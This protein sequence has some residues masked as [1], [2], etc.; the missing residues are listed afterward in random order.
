[1]IGNIRRGVVLV[2]TKKLS[3]AIVEK[4]MTQ[5][6]VAAAIGATPKAFRNKMDKKIF[7]SKE[8]EI[9]NDLLKPENPEELFFA[10]FVT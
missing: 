3:V 1:M 4:G 2:D 7:G 9:M 6:M 5:S 8:L 10:K